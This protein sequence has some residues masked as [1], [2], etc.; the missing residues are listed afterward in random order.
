MGT[1]RDWIEDQI[2]II[3]KTLV[4][5]IFGKEKL[6]KLTDKYEENFSE[7]TVYD[8]ILKA[9]L[10]KL[11]EK[12]NILEAEKLLFDSIDENSRVNEI[13]IALDFYNDLSNLDEKFLH[14]HDFSK[15]K[16]TAGIEN[17]K[18]LVD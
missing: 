10:K 16:I 9:R 18:K 4:G 6:K 5:I 12:G 14:E 2:E 11:I 1:K 8:D 3:S 7:N 15:E 17:I 13:I